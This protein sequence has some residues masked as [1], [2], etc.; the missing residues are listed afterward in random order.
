MGFDL[1]VLIYSTQVMDAIHNAGDKRSGHD[2]LRESIFIKLLVYSACDY[3]FA[4]S[5]QFSKTAC[6]PEKQADIVWSVC[7]GHGV[8]EPFDGCYSA[9]KWLLDNGFYKKS[10][11]QPRQTKDTEQTTNV[12]ISEQSTEEDKPDVGFKQKPICDIKEQVRPNVRLSRKEIDL[13]KNQYSNEDIAKMLDKL[14]EYKTNSG[15]T[16]SSD[17]QAITRWVCRAITKQSAEKPI[18][19]ELPDWMQGV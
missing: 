3:K 18:N 10:N 2:L 12:V 13:L 16:Y 7:L 6:V 19:F 1:N 14:S 11:R 15:K 8:L 5:K 9:M 17:Y 4:N